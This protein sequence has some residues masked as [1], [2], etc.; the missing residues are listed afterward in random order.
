MTNQVS[1]NESF[2]PRS[3]DDVRALVDGELSLVARVGY[4][5]LLLVSLMMTAGLGSLWVTELGLPLRAHV[6][7]GV[8]VLIGVSWAIFALWV[9]TRRR[10]L[11]ASHHVIAGRMSV[12]FTSVF[13]TGC[14]IM[15]AIVGGAASYVVSAIAVLMLGCAVAVLVR[16]RRLRARLIHRRQTLERELAARP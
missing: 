2:V 6:A 4:V 7:F 8:M 15:V 10:V 5:G 1:M 11:L 3:P 13:L 9:L 12:V 14:L 16:A